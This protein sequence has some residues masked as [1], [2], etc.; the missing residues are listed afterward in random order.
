[1]LAGEIMSYI[2]TMKDHDDVIVWERNEHGQRIT[3]KY[4][5]PYYFYQDD[6]T[7]TH[8]TIYNTPV[9]RLDFSN[10]RDYYSA[11]KNLR[12]LWESDIGPELRIISQ[13][14]YGL[15]VP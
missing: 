7:G 3:K 12:N 13:H 4:N 10:G 11:R 1:M 14:Y 9:T 8:T 2:S 6:D 15:P 5:A